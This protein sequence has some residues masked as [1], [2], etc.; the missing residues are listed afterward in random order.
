M[1]V[2]GVVQF[3]RL[4]GYRVARKRPVREGGIRFEGRSVWEAA[5][6][7]DSGLSQACR[8]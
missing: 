2:A 4:L 8:G 5:N 1:R 6:P 7:P 3:G